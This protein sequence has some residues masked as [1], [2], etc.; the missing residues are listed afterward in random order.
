MKKILTLLAALGLTITT[1]AS[2]I[3]CWKTEAQKFNKKIQDEIDQWFKDQKFAD[4]KLAIVYAQAIDFSEIDFNLEAKAVVTAKENTTNILK[5][6]LVVAENKSLPLNAKIDYEV[7]WSKEDSEVTN[8]NMQKI[9]GIINAFFTDSANKFANE[10]ETIAK[11]ATIN[12]ADAE[13]IQFESTVSK[14]LSE[15][16]NN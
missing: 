2:V 15:K 8:E 1:G 13:G 11:A 14:T 10:N 6:K 4:V 9:P 12:F 7:K 16:K 5:I 3:A